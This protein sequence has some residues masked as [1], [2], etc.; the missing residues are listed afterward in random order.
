MWNGMKWPEINVIHHDDV[1]M[2]AMA[3]QI[4]SH[5]IVHSIYYSR[6]RSKKTSKPRVNGLYEDNSPVTDE[7]PT[8]R[9]I[10][11]ENVSMWWRQNVQSFL[12]LL[13]VS[14]RYVNLIGDC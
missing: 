1:T 9:S 13:F 6:R 3:S 10:N 14:S 7:F 12:H 11:A 8:Q 5:T 4:T 2:G